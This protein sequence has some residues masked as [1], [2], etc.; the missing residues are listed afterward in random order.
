MTTSIVDAA[1]TA[2]GCMRNPRRV[3][4]RKIEERLLAARVTTESADPT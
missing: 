3:F 2:R 4:D 1:D